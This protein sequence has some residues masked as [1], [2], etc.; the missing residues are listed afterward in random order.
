MID[1]KQLRELVIR[2]VLEH[3]NLYSPVA[4]NLIA[5]TAAQESGLRYL[6]Q[7]GRG[8]A[9]GLWQMEPATHDDLWTNYLRYNQKLSQLVHDLEL[10]AW[11]AG[12]SEMAGNMYYAAAM[13]RV[14]Y[15]RVKAPLPADPNDVWAIAQYWKSYYNT[16]LGKGKVEEFVLNYEKVRTTAP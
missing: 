3:L 8:P 12:A 6:H 4:E 9:V 13:C 10:P 5:G 7:M 2:P 16:P 14:H 15:K 11:A 1:A